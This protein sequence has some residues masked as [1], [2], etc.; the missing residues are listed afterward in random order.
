MDELDENCSLAKSL[1]C[2]MRLGKDWGLNSAVWLDGVERVMSST[3]HFPLPVSTQ[4]PNSL[5]LPCGFQSPMNTM[6]RRKTAKTDIPLVLGS[7]GCYN[8]AT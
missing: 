3:P 4:A 5:Y 7:Q 6:H 1:G 2:L 8:K